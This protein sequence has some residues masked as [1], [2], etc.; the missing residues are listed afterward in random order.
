M[1]I[2][3]ALAAELIGVLFLLSI[4][5]L[6]GAAAFDL[7]VWRRTSLPLGPVRTAAEHEMADLILTCGR[8][9]AIAVLVLALPHATVVAALLDDR[10]PLRYRMEALLFR[11]DWGLGLAAM[12]VAGVLSVIGYSWAARHRRGGWPI[13]WLGVLFVAIGT[14]LQ[15]HPGDAFVKITVTPLL[16]GIHAVGIGGWLGSFF[17]LVLAER[18]LPAHTSS[19]WTDP[20]GAMLERYFGSSGA[21]AALVLITG[22]LS[23][24]L[25]L[26]SFDDIQGTEY[27]RLLA[28]KVGIVVILLVFNEHHRRHAERKARTAER[29]Q[30]AH[31]LRF[32]AG[33]IGLIMAL[34]ALL[35]NVTPPGSNEVR[36]EVF[37]AMPKGTHKNTDIRLEP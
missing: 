29:A 26:T 22:V 28:G 13:I 16:D 9:S 10:W 32:E 31:S 1:V 8:R 30:L 17:M 25:H 19:P 11:S 3:L 12:L 23:A 15:G 34:T 37:R 24:S 18:R 4:T 6:V 5:L 27:G 35:L 7:L 14:G 20:L 36:A 2:L 33:L 21:L